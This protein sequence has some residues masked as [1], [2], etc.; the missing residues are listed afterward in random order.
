MRRDRID[1]TGRVTL[2]Y[3]ARLFHIGVGRA[4]AGA[5][6]TLLVEDLDVRVVSEHGN[7]TKDYEGRARRWN[8]SRMSRDSCPGAPRDVSRHNTSALGGIRTHNLL[9]RSQM[10]YPLSYERLI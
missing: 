1:K 9:I 7:P 3:L 8:L 5:R 4:H 6:V 2:P 10:L